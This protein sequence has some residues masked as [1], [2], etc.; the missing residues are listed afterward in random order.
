LSNKGKQDRVS[1]TTASPISTTSS[2]ADTTTASPTVSVT[3][4]TV[5]TVPKTL[6]SKT[7]E[8]VATVITENANLRSSASKD[9][10][11]ITAVPS[12]ES[13]S[14]IKQKGVWFYVSAAGQTGWIHGNMIRLNES[15]QA[16]KDLPTSTQYSTKNYSAPQTTT[17]NSGAT[18]KCRDG[19]LSYSAHRRGT[20]SHHGGVAVWY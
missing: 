9:G 1:Q 12:G 3:P 16:A 6:V 15:S 17:E 13:L 5:D 7:A 19:T 14:I 4:K 20:C 11:V 2:Y 10:E 18:A 8:K